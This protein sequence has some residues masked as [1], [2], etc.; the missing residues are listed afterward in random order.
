MKL[1]RPPVLKIAILMIAILTPKVAF[2]QQA[3]RDIYA[4]PENLKVLPEDISSMEL[5][6]TMK[7]FALGLCRIIMRA[8]FWSS[9]GFP[10]ME[11]RR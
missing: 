8:A 1:T 2:A 10:T 6:N 4:N 7:S 5:S 9:K 11:K 3:E